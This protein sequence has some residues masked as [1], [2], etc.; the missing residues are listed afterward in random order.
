MATLSVVENYVDSAKYRRVR[1]QVDGGEC[2]SL[3]FPPGMTVL[4]MK[5]EA[6][7]VISARLQ[8]EQN[9]RTEIQRKRQIS[10]ACDKYAAG[11]LTN[12]QKANLLEALVN[13]WKD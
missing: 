11:T 13:E 4:E 8:D 3:K 2:I 5:A 6:Q 7:R 1:I 10:L 9:Q 12:L